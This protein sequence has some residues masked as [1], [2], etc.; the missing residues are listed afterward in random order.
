MEKVT[1]V[2]LNKL[3]D[4]FGADEFRVVDSKVGARS[5]VYGEEGRVGLVKKGMTSA[6]LAANVKNV[7][8]VK[9]ETIGWVFTVQ[10]GTTI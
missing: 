2:S 7:V 5:S 8:C 1:T 3:K 4:M 6:D 9:H 10:K